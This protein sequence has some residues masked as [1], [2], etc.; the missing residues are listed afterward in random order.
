MR[1]VQNFTPLD[2]QAKTFT[3]SIPPNFNSFS[4]KNTKNEWKWRNLHRWQK[5]YT[6]ASTDGTDKFHLCIC[7]T[8]MKF[9]NHYWDPLDYVIHG[10]PVINDNSHS[11]LVARLKWR[12]LA[13]WGS[14]NLKATLGHCT[15]SHCTTNS[16]NIMIIITR[17]HKNTANKQTLYHNIYPPTCK[18]GVPI[19]KMEI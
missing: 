8:H 16:I 15:T 3:P 17:S 13:H 12:L 1:S 5:F 6:A 18:G 4:D 10:Q 9:C 2:F 11:D 7:W 14:P 19:I